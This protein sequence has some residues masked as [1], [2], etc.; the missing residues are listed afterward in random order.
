MKDQA[1]PELYYLSRKENILK[2]APGKGN[3]KVSVNKVR[4]WADPQ[5]IFNI[6]CSPQRAGQ[7]K[8]MSGWDGAHA[9]NIFQGLFSTV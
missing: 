5:E 8:G 4:G 2:G 6:P 1:L 9:T 7:G 3:G